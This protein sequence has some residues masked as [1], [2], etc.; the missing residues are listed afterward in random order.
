MVPACYGTPGCSVFLLEEWM[1]QQ[2]TINFIGYVAST[3]T[4]VFFLP[5][6]IRVVRLLSAAEPTAAA[7]VSSD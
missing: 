1:I 2:E 7:I 6:L 4:T 3:C 5:Q